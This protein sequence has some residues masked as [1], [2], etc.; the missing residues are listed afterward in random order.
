M[1]QRNSVMTSIA[2]PQTVFWVLGRLSSSFSVALSAPKKE[3][4]S[5]CDVILLIR[6]CLWRGMAVSQEMHRIKIATVE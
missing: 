2:S 4:W 3:D 1:R 5:M 6:G